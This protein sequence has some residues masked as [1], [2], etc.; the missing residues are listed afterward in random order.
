ML[1]T[2]D[3][4]SIPNSAGKDDDATMNDA[5]H[6]HSA[7][8]PF[9]EVDGINY[10]S[11]RFYLHRTIVDPPVPESNVASRART[12]SAHSAYCSCKVPP[13]LDRVSLIHSLDLKAVICATFTLDLAWMSTTFP[14]LCGPKA[15]IPTLILHG[16]KGLATRIEEQKKAAN[17]QDCDSSSDEEDFDVTCE[18]ANA[19]IAATG[20]EDNSPPEEGWGNA[21]QQPEFQYDSLGPSFHLTQILPRW[22]PRSKESQYATREE[23]RKH[24]ESRLGVHHPK[25][26]ILFTKDGSV[27]VLVSTGNLTSPRATDA[28]WMQRFEPTQVPAS[29]NNNNN[30]NNKSNSN[31]RTKIH[32]SQQRRNGSDFGAVLVDFLKCQSNATKRGMIPEEFLQKYVGLGSL[33]ALEQAYQFHKAQVHLI[34]TVP[35]DYESRFAREHLKRDGDFV[36]FL[37]GRQRVADIVS[38]LSESVNE[39]RWR[40]DAWFPESLLSRYDRLVFQPTSIGAQWTLKNLSDVVRSYL[41]NDDVTKVKGSSQPSTKKQKGGRSRYSDA[42]YCADDQKLLERLDIVWPSMKLMKMIEGSTPSSVESPRSVQDEI[43]DE[44]PSNSNSDQP[45]TISSFCFLAAKS[46][47]SI[48]STCLSQLVMCVQRR[49]P[50]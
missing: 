10:Y 28:S 20:K 49:L 18:K 30:N 34:A 15:N 48:Q 39:K 31:G 42:K 26:M 4:T 19:P 13:L 27:I 45:E 32:R 17:H 50:T 40:D 6:V 3:S 35:G 8:V 36:D 22:L 24:C 38:R 25:Y 14:Q 12:D 43:L 16:Q 41:G 23:R 37:Y 29:H 33:S 5:L 2:R 21:L 7:D 11:D 9:V 1:M 47:N 46:F 44:N